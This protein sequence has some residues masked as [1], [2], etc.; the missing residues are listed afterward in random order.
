MTEAEG[1]STLLETMAQLDFFTLVLPFVL[2]YVVFFLALK[3]VDLFSED[4]HAA[5]IAIISAFF[6]AQFIA[7]N[8]FYQQFFIDY[9][10]RLTI[11]IVGIVGLMV[12]VGLFGWSRGD[13]RSPLGVLLIISIV[14]SA[15]F[16]AGGLGPETVEVGEYDLSDLWPILIDTGL[17]W[18][19]LIAGVL[20]WTLKDDG[21]DNSGPSVG[22]RVEWLFG[23][24][25][26]GG[27]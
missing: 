13:L 23:G 15:F 8:P 17:I 5:L 20:A 16:T 4:K 14:A 12:L 11:G 27:G 26:S 22:E 3:Q 2:S 25:G 7:V 24:G 1:F 9:F 6:T 10:G 18:L 19:L 21:N